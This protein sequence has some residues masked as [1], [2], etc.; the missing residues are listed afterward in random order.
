MFIIILFLIF[1]EYIKSFVHEIAFDD[2]LIYSKSAGINPASQFIYIGLDHFVDSIESLL[3]IV[4]KNGYSVK[5]T[6]RSSIPFH[7]LIIFMFDIA[8]I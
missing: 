2:I 1:H 7:I 5:F 3:I 6:S 4:F 8:N